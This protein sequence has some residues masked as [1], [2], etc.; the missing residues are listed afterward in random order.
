MFLKLFFFLR[1][2]E[3]IDLFAGGISETSVEGGTVGPTFACIIAYQFR[4]L[5]IGDRFWHENAPPIGSFTRGMKI[6]MV[7]ITLINASL[8]LYFRF[9]YT[10]VI[11]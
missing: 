2:V 7:T 11:L 4:D 10:A 8:W 9:G 5:K 6:Q 3:D 1:H